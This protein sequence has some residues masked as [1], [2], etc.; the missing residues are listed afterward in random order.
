VRRTPELGIRLA[1]GAQRWEIVRLV[2]RE[3]F[4]LVGAALVCGV[5]AVLAIGRFVNVVL[6]GVTPSDPPAIGAAVA[7]LLGT[8]FLAAYVPARRAGR[9]DLIHALRRE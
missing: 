4:V 8:A 2:L 9:T 7:V 6:F 1:I 3:A 5:I